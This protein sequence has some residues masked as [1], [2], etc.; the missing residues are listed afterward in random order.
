MVHE[1]AV[2]ADQL[3]ASYHLGI[4]TAVYKPS[5]TLAT[6]GGLIAV[7][8]GIAWV[9]VA[10]YITNFV[11]S[12]SFSDFPAILGLVIP[13]IGL[14]F[15]LIGVVII[16]RAFLNRNLRVLVYT[17]GLM[18]MRRNR[19]DVIRWDQIALVCIK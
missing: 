14:V 8:F 10:Y 18:F 17:Y 16:V 7:I 5:T 19:S 11:V 12:S 4:P 2:D 3:A 9:G 15:L 13:L 1:I 6:F